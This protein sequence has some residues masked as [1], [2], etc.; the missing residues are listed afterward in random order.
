MGGMP[1][2]FHFTMRR[3]LASMTLIAAGAA[4]WPLSLAVE[5]YSTK[6][7]GFCVIAIAALPLSGVT[8]LFSRTWAFIVFVV[9]MVMGGLFFLGASY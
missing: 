7:F 8:L 2:R 5:P 9:T 3:L 1:G 6:L 4:C